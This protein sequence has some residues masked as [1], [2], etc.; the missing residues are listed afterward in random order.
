MEQLF[1][2]GRWSP[3]TR[4]AYESFWR[5]WCN[6][7]VTNSAQQFPAKPASVAAYLTDRSATVSTS[8]LQGRIAM[9]VAVHKI[10]GKP[11][12]VNETVIRDTWAEI[13]RQKGTAKTP[14]A[15]LMVDD[16]KK[17][18]DA[19]PPENLQDRAVILFAIASM[20]RRSEIVALNRDD[21]VIDDASMT[22]NV[23][24]S[25]TDKSGKGELVPIL[26]SPTI[27]CPIAALERWLSHADITAGPIFRSG[28]ARMPA[29]RVATI[30][31]RWAAHI[32]FNPTK[33]GAH[34]FR[35]GGITT[36]FRNG[37]KIEEVM[38]L[39][40]HKTVSIALGYVEAQRAVENPALRTL[41]L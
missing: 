40:R 20:M 32:G 13:R 15:A 1:D 26:R 8:S 41:G 23:R 31:K 35:R 25:K 10:K 38:L 19:I 37:A 7:C 18:I 12:R 6:W 16:V 21:L 3:A 5:D 9:L 11:L 33:I 2:R 17:I 4:Q 34:S 28:D 36:M 30:A 22:I 27:Y 24:R 39:S 14:K 29:R